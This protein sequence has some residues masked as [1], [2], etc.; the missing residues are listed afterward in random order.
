M[1]DKFDI[2]KSYTFNYLDWN[3]EEFFSAS[4]LSEIENDISHL[5]TLSFY[6]HR[7]LARR[8]YAKIRRRISTV[9]D[10]KEKE[11]LQNLAH[12]ISLKVKEI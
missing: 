12:L 4:N 8:L 11:A 7:K 9:E 2:V 1:K 3:Q 5:Q 6:G 10:E